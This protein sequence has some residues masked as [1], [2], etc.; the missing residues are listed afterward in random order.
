MILE[1]K[2]QLHDF[3]I[4]IEDGAIAAVDN[5]KGETYTA[6][7]VIESIGG[8]LKVNTKSYKTWCNFDKLKLFLWVKSNS[9]S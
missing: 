3:E 4:Y 7:A 2:N 6:N 5:N 9:A 8:K 1:L